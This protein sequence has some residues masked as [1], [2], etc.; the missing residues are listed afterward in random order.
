MEWPGSW[1]AICDK[2]EAHSLAQELQHELS[3]GHP[4]ACTSLTVIGRCSAWDDIVVSIDDGTTQ[5]AIV[6]LTWS[7]KYETPPWPST[8]FFES[9]DLLFQ[10]GE[11]C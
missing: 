7:G 5:V 9:L 10:S 1:V 2:H 3:F 4:L 8:T 11:G 6:H